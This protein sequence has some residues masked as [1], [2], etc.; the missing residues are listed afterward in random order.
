MKT[1]LINV[2]NDD[3][4]QPRCYV[5]TKTTDYQP[6]TCNVLLLNVLLPSGMSSCCCKFLRK[7]STHI[8]SQELI[9]DLREDPL[10]YPVQ[11][12]DED[13]SQVSPGELADDF[14][15]LRLDI[16]P[17]QCTE[18]SVP[19]VPRCTIMI[20]ACLDILMTEFHAPVCCQHQQ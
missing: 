7:Q 14:V 20:T 1:S 6:I 10:P 5:L 9:V 11:C 17:V 3:H 13:D 15:D 12:T 19:D 2:V 8:M 4:V 16:F 18:P